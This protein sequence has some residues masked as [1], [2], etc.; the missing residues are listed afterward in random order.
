VRQRA[1]PLYLIS[2]VLLLLTL[3]VGGL[4]NA[5][6]QHTNRV[7]L[8]IK[9][10]DGSLVTRCVEFNEA[11]ISGYE[12]LKRTGLSIVAAFDSGMGAGI[13]K[14]EDQGCPKASCMT[15]DVPNYWS[16]WHLQGGSWI[17]SNVGASSHTVH[18]GDVEGWRWGTGD[19]PPAMPFDQICAPPATDTPV[20][21]G[22]PIPVT[23][24]PV[25]TSTPIPATSTP[26][27]PTNTP[28]PSATPEPE[29]NPTSAPAPEAWFRLDQN[30]VAAGSCTV[31]RWDTSD[32]REVY[33]DGDEVDIIG[34][35]EVCPGTSTD[36][37]LRVVGSK[38]ETYRL[39]LG[40]TGSA[41]AA[42]PPPQP[43]EAPQSPSP[44]VDPG[45]ATLPPASPTAPA[46]ESAPTL[47]L[48]PDSA[49]A[50]S[51]SPTETPAVSSSATPTPSPTPAQI[52]QV[53]RVATVAQVAQVEDVEQQPSPS[54]S[55]ESRSPFLPI[56]YA[57]FSLIVG[58][59]LGWL[60]Y[61]LRFRSERA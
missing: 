46:A 24:T 37:E 39:T 23:D 36:Y 21:T 40:V 57:V 27:P 32:A 2:I 50:T 29:Q 26:V 16:Y 11:E 55:E 53:K 38:E 6:A 47:T 12:V 45:E 48:G 61:I 20:P 3:V 7:G 60:V 10:G 5:S 15:C 14:I 58:G 41:S 18:N 31:L 59:L 22:T 1:N 49:T 25:P 13:C 19:A 34:S 8:V 43:T 30:P 9:F 51:S 56:G 42:T 33:L 52:A 17:Y 54:D 35:R 28:F 4:S 44:T